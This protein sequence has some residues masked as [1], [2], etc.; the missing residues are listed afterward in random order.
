M[1]GPEPV[2]AKITTCFSISPW[3]AP[4]VQWI[5]WNSPRVIWWTTSA[6]ISERERSSTEPHMQKLTIRE[7]RLPRIGFGRDMQQLNG[8]FGT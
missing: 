7:G 2:F 4:E 5:T 6:Y 3:V 1:P 8:F